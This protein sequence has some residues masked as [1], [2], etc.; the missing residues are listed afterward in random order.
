M[1]T[2]EQIHGE[3]HAKTSRMGDLARTI[4]RLHPQ[5]EARSRC[6][7][8]YVSLRKECRKLLPTITDESIYAECRF[9]M[10]TCKKPTDNTGAPVIR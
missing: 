9:L 3:I 4:E 7:E 5:S 8:E 1:N 2:N 6:I 10:R